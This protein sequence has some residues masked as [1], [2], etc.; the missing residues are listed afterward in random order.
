MNQ[1]RNKFRN[2]LG[3]QTHH[4]AINIEENPEEALAMVEEFEQKADE[5]IIKTINHSVAEAESLV[6]KENY[7]QA[8]QIL[9]GIISIFKAAEEDLG[10]RNKGIEKDLAKVENELKN[11]VYQQEDVDAEIIEKHLEAIK[12]E[13]DQELHKDIQKE[14]K[15][16]IAEIKDALEV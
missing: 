9:F 11:E 6:E 15:K 12:Q 16:T 14:M 5:L 4:L 8:G 13:V 2:L 1:V 7:E 10:V 3:E